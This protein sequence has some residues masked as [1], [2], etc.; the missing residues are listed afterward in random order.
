MSLNYLPGLNG[1]RFFAAFFVVISHGHL[2][3]VKLNIQAASKLAFFNRGG[4][5]VD[6]FFTLSGFLISYLLLKEIKETGTVSIRQFYL[7]RVFRI[8]PLYFLFIFIGFLLLGLL[9]PLIYHANYFTFSIPEGLLLFIL[10]LPNYAAKN[11]QVG[12]LNP[13]WSIGVEEQFYLFWA[14]LVKTFRNSVLQMILAF[15]F[16]SLVLYAVNYYRIFSMSENWFA[17][18]MTQ[19]FYAMAI[20]SMFG[21]ILHVHQEGY[22]KSFF[23]SNAFQSFVWIVIAW[24]FLFN[25]VTEVGFLFKV[26]LAFLFGFLIL[27][28]SLSTFKWINLEQKS[29]RYLGT[30]SYGIYMFHMVVDY[31]LRLIVPFFQSLSISNYLIAASYYF[32]LCALS[33]LT[34][35][36]S[37]RYFESYFLKIKQKFSLSPVIR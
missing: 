23:T 36:F 22:K 10:F 30:I 20:G 15:I 26:G 16:L 33:I 2:S 4:D 25:N 5:A 21:Y 13:L 18:F 29:L 12:L 6:F 32:A 11:Y 31:G 27:N 35:S 3:L 19:K 37:F 1:L 9:Y 7:R 14:P 34:A 28:V 8:W 17:F 24:H